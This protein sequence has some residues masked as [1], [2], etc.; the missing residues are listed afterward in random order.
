[1][2][3]HPLALHPVLSGKLSLPSGTVH[4][5]SAELD[6]P[7]DE[8]PAFELLS[9]DER[10]R[11]TQ[12]RFERNRRRFTIARATLRVLLA[13]YVAR[14]ANE[15][16]FIYDQYGK[17]AIAGG[18]PQF[19]LSHSGELAVIAISAHLPLGVDV[20]QLSRSI[21]SDALIGSFASANERAAFAA[22]PQQGRE[23]AFFYW[24]TRKEAV[25]KALGTGHSQ[26]MESFDVS[27]S[28]DDVRLTAVGSEE[29]PQHI[30]LSNIPLPPGYIGSLAICGEAHAI[31]THQFQRQE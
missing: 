19:N 8:I 15:I 14:R 17:P 3:S 10:H 26:P 18:E 4:L 12:F 28:L 25:L 31:E 5:W 30:S 11:A 27:I 13:R 2:T 7:E 24:W 22:L 1:M 9:V 23:L 16:A 21:D 20:E 6:H 29:F